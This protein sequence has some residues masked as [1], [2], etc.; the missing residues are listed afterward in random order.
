MVSVY[1]VVLPV[2]RVLARYDKKSSQF[3]PCEFGDDR[4]TLLTTV[5]QA[6][7]SV[8]EVHGDRGEIGWKLSPGQV[9]DAVVFAA[10]I[11]AHPKLSTERIL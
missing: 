1:R 10:W 7:R 3:V 4:G 9:N 2:Q 8:M 11:K 6:G 5:D